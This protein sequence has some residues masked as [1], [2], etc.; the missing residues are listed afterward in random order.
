MSWINK[1]SHIQNKIDELDWELQRNKLE[2]GYAKI[3]IAKLNETL[4]ALLRYLE[5]NM[6]VIPAS[7]GKT[8]I[9]SNQVP[10]KSFTS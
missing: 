5:L 9:T 6:T 3:E 10:K 8:I 7:S 2:I 1:N 4:S